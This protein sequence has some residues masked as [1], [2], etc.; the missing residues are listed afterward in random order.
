MKAKRMWGAGGWG[1]PP[2]F[3]WGRPP[4]HRQPPG[5]GPPLGE[6]GTGS[7]GVAPAIWD[8]KEGLPKATHCPRVCC[9]EKGGEGSSLALP[10]PRLQGFYGQG[11]AWLRTGSRL[12]FC[13]GPGSP[14]LQEL[15][16]RS[17]STCARGFGA[18]TGGPW[19]GPALGRPCLEPQAG[20]GH[21]GP[22]SPLH[23]EEEE[24][25]WN[26]LSHLWNWGRPAGEGGALEQPGAVERHPRWGGSL[27]ALAKQ[28][29]GEE[30]SEK[31]SRSSRAE[32]GG[33]GGQPLTDFRSLRH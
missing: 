9:P 6:G 31:G 21:L 5:P 22:G 18:L 25:P 30:G 15:A 7:L 29:G 33:G 8:D 28:R 27:R 19:A 3:I 20:R 10:L 26:H 2:G 32:G 14:L 23:Q 13:R 24:S 17:A 11:I 4:L 1:A 12:G 16:C